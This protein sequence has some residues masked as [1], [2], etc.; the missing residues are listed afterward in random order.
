MR[1]M[2]VTNDFS[3]PV[4]LGNPSEITVREL[5]ER[6]VQITQSTSEIIVQPLPVDDPPRRRPDIS[7]AYEA[8]AWRPQTTL[9]EGLQLTIR[10]VEERLEQGDLSLLNTDPAKNRQ[11]RLMGANAI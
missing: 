5:A 4:N 1:L 11:S 3:G 8:L 10:D 6:I 2:D 7:L 9:E